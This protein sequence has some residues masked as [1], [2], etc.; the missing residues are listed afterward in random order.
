MFMRSVPKADAVTTSA[1]ESVKQAE[2]YVEA[3]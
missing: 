2:K 1:V 3:K